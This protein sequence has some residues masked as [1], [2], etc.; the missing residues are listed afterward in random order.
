MKKLLIILMASFFI[1]SGLLISYQ[2]NFTV[3]KPV[4]LKV[5]YKLQLKV[6]SEK[7]RKNKRLDPGTLHQWKQIIKGLHSSGEMAD[8]NS[9]I[10]NVLKDSYQ[11]ITQDLAFYRDKVKFF[12]NLKKQMRSHLR[13]LRNSRRKTRRK[14]QYAGKRRRYFIKVKD[15]STALFFSG[16]NVTPGKWGRPGSLNFI[17]PK[18]NYVLKTV[19]ITDKEKLEDE[20]KKMEKKLQDIGDDSAKANM[21]LQNALLN[22]QQLMQKMSNIQKMLNDSAKAIIRNLK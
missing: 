3:K 9:M 18:K 8:I 10:Q 5:K 11:E 1:N 21:D 14:T 17:P 6:I 4:N 19:E 7:I 13:E 16:K 2:R 12:N 22:N 15:F 20:I